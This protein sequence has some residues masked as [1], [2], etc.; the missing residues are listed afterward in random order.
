MFPDLSP[1]AGKQR[2]WEEIFKAVRLAGDDPVAAWDAHIAALDR[3]LEHLNARLYGQLADGV[4]GDAFEN[5]GV[6]RRRQQL[7][8]AY[9]KNI[10]AGTLR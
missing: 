6:T 2:L 1:E 5:P 4:A 7:A 9:Q 8:I 3:V 10:I